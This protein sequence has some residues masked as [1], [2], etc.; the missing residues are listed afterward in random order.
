MARGADGIRILGRGRGP[1]SGVQ[2]LDGRNPVR[3]SL[4]RSAPQQVGR[5]G[6]IP[7]PWEIDEHGREMPDEY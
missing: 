4:D 7:T 5:E 1:S 3:P 2:G 6:L